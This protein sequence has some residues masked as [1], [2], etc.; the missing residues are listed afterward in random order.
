M[1]GTTRDA[2]R[3]V[4]FTALIAG[5]ALLPGIQL[6]GVPVPI[7]LQT[8]AIMLAAT[9]LGPRRGPLAVL[10]YLALGLAGLPILS[11]GAHGLQTLSKP[12]VGYLLSWPL[13]AALTG[14]L[15]LRVPRQRWTREVPLIFLCAMAGSL[16]FIH[17]LGIAG[18][19]WR[20]ELPAA[21][22]ISMGASFVPGDLLKN[23]AVALIATAVHRALPGLLP[24]P[25]APQPA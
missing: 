11:G 7:T 21:Q 13:A 4:A 6:P 1:T 22:A 9:C 2:A 14:A 12:S 17:P 20:L 25:G 8:F 5:C 23:S 24:R 16:L 10:L 19:A 18:L 3:I 15:V